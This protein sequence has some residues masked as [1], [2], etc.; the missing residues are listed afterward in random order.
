VALYGRQEDAIAKAEELDEAMS[1][2]LQVE[3]GTTGR[4]VGDTLA[5]IG[6]SGMEHLVF[7][8]KFHVEK[9]II[10]PPLIIAP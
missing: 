7:P 3:L 1:G 2:L 4:T 10:T 6:V 8:T 9:R 5:M